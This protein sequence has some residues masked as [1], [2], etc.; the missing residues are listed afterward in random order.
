MLDLHEGCDQ[1]AP[2]GVGGG[3]WLQELFLRLLRAPRR[4]LLGLRQGRAQAFERPA[5]C[6]GRVPDV[7]CRRA[8]QGPGR[9][10]EHLRGAAPIHCGGVQD[11]RALLQGRRKRRLGGPGHPEEGAALVQHPRDFPTRRAGH[12]LQVCEGPPRRELPGHLGPDGEAGGGAPTVRGD[13]QAE[14]G[15]QG[16]PQGHRAAVHLPAAGHQREQADEPLAEVALRG[17]PQDRARL[18]ADRPQQTRCVQPGGGAHDRPPRG[19]AEPL[20]RP[21]ANVAAGLHALVRG[22]LPA[23]ARERH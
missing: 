22:Q 14:A 3:L 5:H 18:R 19:G 12:D 23:E 9:A 4:P 20:R 1:D 11:L 13:L 16:V 10:Q 21:A 15:G 6:S 8:E 7:G 2:A 17:P